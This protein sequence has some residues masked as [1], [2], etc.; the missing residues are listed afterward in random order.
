MPFADDLISDLDD[1]QESETQ[2][3]PKAPLPLPVPSKKGKNLSKKKIKKPVR[4]VFD[5][6]DDTPY[7]KSVTPSPPASHGVSLEAPPPL[8][9]LEPETLPQSEVL[10]DEPLEEPAA[11][12][13]HDTTAIDEPEPPPNPAPAPAPPPAARSPRPPTATPVSPAVSPLY[14]PSS[15]YGAPQHYTSLG[16]YRP[17]SSPGQHPSPY[18]RRESFATSQ[19]SPRPR[20]AQL[21]AHSRFIEPPPPHMPQPHYFGLPDM[22]FNLAPKQEQGK[23][24]GAD[25]YCCVFDSFADAGDAASARKA[26]D[27]LLVGSECGLDAYRVLPDKLEVVGRLEGLRGAVIA[28]KVLPHTELHDSVQAQR[29]LVA[30]IMH[31]PINDDRRDSGNEDDSPQPPSNLYQTT[32]EVYSLQTQ[33]QIATLYRSTTVPREQPVVGHLSLPPSPVGELHLD[34]A[35]SFITVS[36]GK[37]GE[38]FVFS[39]VPRAGSGETMFRC[40]G[41][42]WT[43]LQQRSEP[44]RPTSSSET[45]NAASNIE[46]QRRAPSLSLSSRWLALVPPYT[47]ASISIQGSPVLSAD[48]PQ[49]Y[50][51]ATHVAPP[52]PPITCEVAGIDAEGTLS[53]LSRKAAQGLVKAS[54]RGYEMG[55]QGWKE[56][57]HPTL[58]SAQ[59]SHQRTASHDASLFPPTNATAD[60]PKRLAKEPAL[61]SI[62]DLQRL[63][64]AEEQ[65]L[66]QA[67]PPLA[68]FALVE[69]CNH[70]SFSPDGLRLMTSNRKGETSTVWDLAHVAHGCAKLTG[71][72]EDVEVERGPHIMPIHRITRSSPSVITDS[73]W[74]RDGD[75]LGLLTTHGTVHL[76]EI[77][78]TAPSKKRKRRATITGTAQPDKADATVSV[79]QPGMSPPSSNGFLGGWARS[80]SQSVSTQVN[81]IKTQNMLPTT[82]AGFRET[83]AA[84]SFAGRK[85]VAKGLGQGYSAAK[86]GA[87]DMWHAEDNKVRLK[88]M[89]EAGATAGCLRWVQRQGN[90][91]CLAVVCGGSVYLHPVQRVTRRKGEIMVSGLK[92]D[93]HYKTF[94]LPRI[95]TSRDG[96]GAAMKAA[97]CAGE[98]PHGFWSLR[99]APKDSLRLSAANRKGSGLALPTAANE[100][101]TNPPY[102]PFHIDSRVNIYAFDDSFGLGS[103]AGL[104]PPNNPTLDFR[105]RGHS[106]E[107]EEPWGFGEPLPPSTKVNERTSSEYGDHADADGDD[108][109]EVDDVAGQVESRLTIEPAGLD[110]GGEQIR[111]T[112]RRSRRAGVGGGFDL[113]EDDGDAGM[114]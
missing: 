113:M 11:A 66:K 79:S 70:L 9:E 55:I 22:G 19:T 72:D 10:L 103:Q 1:F 76:H 59:T 27:A 102:C 60:D 114:M 86:S 69:G 73:V 94:A 34:A 14:R 109:P 5:D 32:V 95:S 50:G 49:A 98:G 8:P 51:L 89:Q 21:A 46:K 13:Q 58:P 77:P 23:P 101:E 56:L 84:A 33:Q 110:G 92:R 29:P 88:A 52:Q 99:A 2:P 90:G 108:D 61:V 57:T 54:Q 107:H 112:S 81:A 3:P 20:L 93:K 111:V 6:E 100:V 43:A 74:S 16:G 41:K 28:A 31:G 87:S 38:V 40:I 39:G 85:A 47:T 65:K 106:A 45:G 48:S 15:L 96:G 53:W 37:S 68:T 80:W 104:H 105:S 83:A 97:S 18:P 63:L 44:S 12:W 17:N 67:P 35:G 75:W 64:A 62:I 24:A 30:L 36:S 4:K 7:A 26:R 78:L 71:H 42:F 91:S 82:F 25:G